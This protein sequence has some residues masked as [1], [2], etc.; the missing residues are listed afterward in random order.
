MLKKILGTIGSRYLI[1]FLNL[2][3]IFI[4]AKVLGIEGV[5]MIGLIVASVNI[6]VI[7]PPAIGWISSCWRS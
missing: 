5:G 4:N 6:A 2:A 7:Y 1:A 3:L